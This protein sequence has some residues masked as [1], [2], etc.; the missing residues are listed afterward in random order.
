MTKT[1]T[2]QLSRTFNIFGLRFQ[3]WLTQMFPAALGPDTASV[4]NGR[5]SV[6]MLDDTQRQVLNRLIAQWIDMHQAEP[7]LA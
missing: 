6:S 5:K 3:N 2:H 4:L 1:L 7:E